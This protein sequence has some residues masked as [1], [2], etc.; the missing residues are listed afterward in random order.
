M[1]LGQPLLDETSCKLHAFMLSCWMELNG[2]GSLMVTWEWRLQIWSDEV[3]QT[4]GLAAP[5]R[6]P[7]PETARGGVWHR[8]RCTWRRAM[9]ECW[10]L[11]LELPFEP[12]IHD[13][14]SFALVAQAGLRP[15]HQTLF[16][17]F[18]R[19]VVCSTPR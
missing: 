11:S 12:R 7:R 3:E 4:L 2:S 18:S 5:P 14:V 17:A 9:Q 10:L 16:Y 15:V 19:S 13:S 8:C 1:T 6:M